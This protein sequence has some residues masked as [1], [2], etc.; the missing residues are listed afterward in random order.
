LR[1]SIFRIVWVMD[2]TCFIAIVMYVKAAAWLIVERTGSSFLA[3]LVQTAVFLPMFALSLSPD[4]LADTTDRRRVMLVSQGMLSERANAGDVRSA[5]PV[6]P[7]ADQPWPR[8]YP[9]PRYG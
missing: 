6:T 1:H 2:A 3:A 8:V 5:G 7:L 9:A 4:V